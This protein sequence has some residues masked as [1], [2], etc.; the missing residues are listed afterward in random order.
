MP[1]LAGVTNSHT[2]V[3]ILVIGCVAASRIADLIHR[4]RAHVLCDGVNDVS[5]AHSR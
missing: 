5:N 4:T 2:V 1:Q 3:Q